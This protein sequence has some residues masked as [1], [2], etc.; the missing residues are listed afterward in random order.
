MARENQQVIIETAAT[1]LQQIKTSAESTVDPPALL[2]LAEA[3]SLVINS[4][5]RKPPTPPRML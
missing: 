1:L 4:N 5:S 2:Q 3:F